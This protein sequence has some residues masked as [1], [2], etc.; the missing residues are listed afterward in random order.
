MTHSIQARL[1]GI[2]V[3]A[4]LVVAAL[5]A[6]V[7]AFAA[8]PGADPSGSSADAQPT[9]AQPTDGG[10]VVYD[11]IFLTPTPDATPVGEVRA[12][13]SRP[14]PT[15][16]ATDSIGGPAT[17]TSGSGV[18]AILLGLAGLSSMVLLLG[19]VPAARRR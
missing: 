13:T 17:R 5:A 2:V 15:P 11:P 7:A 4:G 18:E 16:P 12:I 19:R 9:E 1:A 6:P 14:D 10:E 8:E 3:A